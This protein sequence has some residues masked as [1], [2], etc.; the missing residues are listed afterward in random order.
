MSTDESKMSTNESKISTDESKMSTNESKIS[1]DESKISKDE[2]KI[3]TD[4]SKM[5]TDESEISTDESEISIDESEISTDESE[6]SIDENEM[7]TNETAK[8]CCIQCEY[9]TNNQSNLRRHL[10]T[11]KHKEILNLIVF[12]PE[13]KHQ[14]T[15]CHKI[16]KSQSG[17]WS[18]KHNCKGVFVQ[19]E[20]IIVQEQ[21]NTTKL[22]G[23]KK[24]SCHIY[25][26]QEREFIKTKENVYKVGKTRQLNFQRFK[27]YPKGSIVLL[28][29]ECHDCDKSEN[30]ILS[31]LRDKF[32]R[33]PDYGSE[34]FEGDYIEMKFEINKILYDLDKI[35]YEKE[36][37]N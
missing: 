30:L 20:T 11:I 34:Y 12:D 18:H 24:Q 31:M 14:C 13:C 32:K 27:Q 36:R 19:E 15:K 22:I 5:S 3:S 29:S 17:L 4:E 21:I 33:C 25:L 1:T 2:S 10:L 8:F 7:S 23:W 26:L 6:I 35:Q 9:Y 37:K 28:H 16:Y